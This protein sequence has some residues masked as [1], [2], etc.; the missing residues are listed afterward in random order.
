MSILRP[1]CKGDR[2]DG[3]IPANFCRPFRAPCAREAVY[4]GLPCPVGAALPW[5]TT[6]PPR[7]GSIRHRR[8]A[9]SAGGDSFKR[10]VDARNSNLNS[11]AANVITLDLN[12]IT[13]DLNVVAF[14][15]NVIAIAASRVA[16]GA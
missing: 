4:P 1:P 10:S 11:N 14:D 7:W 5:A 13:F 16:F 3:A 9:A 6:L 15:S 2:T 12:A 8:A